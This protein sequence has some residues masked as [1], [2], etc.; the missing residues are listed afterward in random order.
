MDCFNAFYGSNW[1]KSHDKL[2]FILRFELV[3]NLATNFVANKILAILP[4]LT[5]LP[6]AFW[7]REGFRR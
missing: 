2:G 1:L 4:Y 5:R 6:F 7:T 3:V